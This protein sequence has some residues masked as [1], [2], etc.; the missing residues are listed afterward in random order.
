MGGPGG[1]KRGSGMSG[2]ATSSQFDCGGDGSGDAPDREARAWAVV[3]EGYEAALSEMRPGDPGY[4]RLGRCLSK[5]RRLAGVRR[6][7]L[8]RSPRRVRGAY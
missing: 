6:L 3:A 5:A 4:A 1:A 7:A 8:V 2:T